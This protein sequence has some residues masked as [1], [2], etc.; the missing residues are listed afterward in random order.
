LEGYS[1]LLPISVFRINGVVFVS[2]R[3]SARSLRVVYGVL[4]MTYYLVL[5][6]LLGGHYRSSSPRS[7]APA[8][9]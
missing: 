1:C 3:S 8:T 7:I 6:F 5:P 2:G 4:A 9:L